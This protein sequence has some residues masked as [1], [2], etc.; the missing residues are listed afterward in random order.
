MRNSS[1][2]GAVVFIFILLLFLIAVAY[3]VGTSTDA[4]ALA[5]GFQ[6]VSYAV[7]GRT[8]SGSFAGYPTGGGTAPAVAF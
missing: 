3:Y 4:L 7:S 5:K 8:A 1:S 6:Q 2:P